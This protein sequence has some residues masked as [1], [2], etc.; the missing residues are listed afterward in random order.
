MLWMQQLQ[1]V[2]WRQAFVCMMTAYAL[3]CFATGYYLVRSWTGKDIR[4]VDSGSVGARN[5]SR[6]LGKTGFVLTLLGDFGKGALA[7]WATR[8]F[9]GNNLIAG[10]AM[11]SVVAGHV[12]P[13]QLRFHGGKGAATSLGALLLW[14]VRLALTYAAFFS[15]AFAIT[16]KTVLPGLFAFACLPLA[17]FLLTH[18]GLTLTIV[19]VL[20]ATVLFAHRKNF[21]EEM[22]ALAAR[23]GIEAKPEHPKL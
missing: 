16:R 17:T 9:T 7:V 8:H 23:R 22:P 19:A 3:G 1:S 2:D 12:W 14:D 13:V 15:A 10:L 5:V 4:D 6:L 11:L 18:D 21:V 20:S